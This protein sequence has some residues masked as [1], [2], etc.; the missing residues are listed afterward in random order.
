M[1]IKFKMC[2]MYSLVPVHLSALALGLGSK[3]PDSPTDGQVLD[4][5]TAL[6]DYISILLS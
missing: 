3:S 1:E 4:A 2:K 6:R 5:R